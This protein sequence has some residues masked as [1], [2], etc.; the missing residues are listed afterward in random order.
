MSFSNFH[1]KLLIG[2]YQDDALACD[3]HNL[4]SVQA[5]YG[6]VGDMKL[7]SMA[8][9]HLE[10][11]GK[12]ERR[13]L[14]G[15][16]IRGRLTGIGITYIDEKYGDKDGVGTILEPASETDSALAKIVPASDRIVTLNHNHPKFSETLEAL[17][18]AEQA[19]SSSNML[20]VDEKSDTI[21]HI[22]LG[23]K[24]LSQG[25]SFAIG[26]IRY[27]L[28]DRLKKSFESL[29][30]DAFKVVLVAAFLAVA[31]FLISLI[32]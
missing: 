20:T 22:S 18:E 12:I 19:I 13:E 24:L 21:L 5:K 4:T 25:K 6:L 28:L 30:E 23:K 26:A 7:L 2:L 32:S 8:A 1:E 15:A 9:K 17:A 29:I 3:W 10:T 27:L 16:E 14:V 11:E 31:A